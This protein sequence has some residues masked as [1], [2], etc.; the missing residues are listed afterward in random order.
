M[1]RKFDRKRSPGSLSYGN[2]EPR[3]LLATLV[4][5]EADDTVSID[6]VDADTVN[7]TLN[8]TTQENVDISDGLHINLKNGFDK[9]L[10]DHR[11]EADV[12]VFETE[13]LILDGGDNQF[14]IGAFANPKPDTIKPAINAGRINN[15]IRFSDVMTIRSGAGND[16][17]NVNTSRPYS[18][19]LFGGEGDDI[20]RFSTAGEKVVGGI[21][22]GDLVEPLH[23]K[24]YGEAG[25]DRFSMYEFSIDRAYGGE[26]FDIVDYRQMSSAVSLSVSDIIDGNTG[27]DRIFGKVDSQN[28]V[29]AGFEQNLVGDLTWV[30]NGDWTTVSDF[31]GDFKVELMNF[32]QFQSDTNNTGIDHAWILATTFDIRVIDMNWVHIGSKMNRSIANLDSINHDIT[33][34]KTTGEN[35]LPGSVEINNEAGAGTTSSYDADGVIRGLTNAEIR[36]SD[37][38]LAENPSQLP[39]LDIYGSQEV[40]Y[41]VLKRVW[42]S[43]TINGNG[44]DDIFMVGGAYLD[45]EADLSGINH[46]LVLRGDE[47]VDRIFANDLAGN[48]NTNYEIRDNFFGDSNDSFAFEAVA[49]YDMEIVRVYGSAHSQNNF[50]VTPS[51]TTIFAVDGSANSADQ[52]DNLGIVG[53]KDVRQL[54]NSAGFGSWGFAG[55]RQRVHFFGVEN[56]VSNESLDSIPPIRMSI[57]AI[58]NRQH[59]Y[60]KFEDTV[61]RSQDELDSFIENMESESDYATSVTDALKALEVDFT[62]KNFL[63][64][65]HTETS[66]SNQIE[67]GYPVFDSN[68][69]VVELARKIPEIGTADMAYYAYA[70]EVD[71]AIEKVIFT[72]GETSTEIVN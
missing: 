35:V 21:S 67:L 34:L 52:K 62:S 65:T 19:E 17:F 49:F 63:F 54:S 48:S 53:Q 70:Y 71:K 37:G 31:D 42:T 16:D 41:F 14:Q 50:T 57:L 51:E 2:L 69:V 18:L 13:E 47:G 26:G 38:V 3:N 4:G 29:A 43:T 36:F 59:V 56:P 22:G 25:N 8:D 7:I 45:A 66:G 6:F 27:N 1:S 28:T 10:I 32:S 12:M 40:D 39:S 30:I 60:S 58:P 68:K 72:D 44:G 24:A 20:F 46:A 61:L 55:V 15:N 11:I 33:I 23:V 5:T 64:F 9:L